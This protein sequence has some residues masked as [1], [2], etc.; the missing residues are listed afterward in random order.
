MTYAIKVIRSSSTVTHSSELEKL[1]KK[2]VALTDL[3]SI[4]RKYFETKIS[5]L[6]RNLF[7]LENSFTLKDG[8]FTCTAVALHDKNEAYDCL[9]HE[10][11]N[12]I[13]SYD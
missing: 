3:L 11:T 6:K 12:M 10:F 13:H 1:E 8:E 4:E 2:N 9:D 5:N 7:L